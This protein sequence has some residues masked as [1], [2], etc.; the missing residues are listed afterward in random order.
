MR[1]PI[2][3]KAQ[4]ICSA[5][6]LFDLDPKRRWLNAAA[7][8]AA[9]SLRHRREEALHRRSCRTKAE[10]G[11]SKAVPFR[12]RSANEGA[13]IRRSNAKKMPFVSNRSIFPV[14]NS[15]LRHSQ[16]NRENPALATTAKGLALCRYN[17][18]LCKFAVV[19][20]CRFANAATVAP[21]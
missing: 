11:T 1:P 3:S 2:T 18:P 5:F 6:F 12:F 7:T 10:R 16:P 9:A 20:L 21:L 15:A 13:S 17:G 19:P 14:R 8:A 4:L